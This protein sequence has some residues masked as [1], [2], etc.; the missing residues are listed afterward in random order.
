M[1]EQMENTGLER[2]HFASDP[3]SGLQAIIAI[4][5]T[6]LGPA[7]GGC[8]FIEYDSDAD[9]IFDACRL[10]RG[11]SYKAAL[12]DLPHGGAKSV[13]IKPRRP[14][15]RQQLMQA[16]G[17]FVDNLGGAYIAAMDSGTQTSD[18]DAIRSS[19]RYVTCTS[20]IGDPSPF[21]AR[22]VVAGIQAAVASKLGH[23]N[24][25]GISV[26]I[27]GL[28]HVGFAVAQQLHQLGA[29]LFVAD[30]DRSRME[31][32]V[33][34]LDA[35][36]VACDEILKVRVDVLCPCGLGAIINDQSIQQLHCRII[37][38]SANNQ[39]L[40]EQHGEQLQQMGILYAPDYLINA[41]GLIFAALQHTGHSHE[42]ID[43]KVCAIGTALR[44][45]FD[46]AERSGTPTHRIANQ[47][48][49][50]I[51]SEARRLTSAA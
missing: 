1:F 40:D 50:A 13:I 39:L 8:R 36:P 41:G 43:R 46:M 51:I 31:A 48:A 15:D 38:G 4:H 30:I 19:T 20:D 32:A 17:R 9:A 22:G 37:A 2:L 3:E 6:I 14:F 28:G 27:Q 21:T 18:M 35:I 5:S 16:F 29:R 42:A 7:I 45:L 23:D 10:A 24:L 11:M 34:Q 25:S 26:A 44:Q 49:D 33:N 12:A 47:Q